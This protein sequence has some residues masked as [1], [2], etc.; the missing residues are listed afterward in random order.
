MF[1]LLPNAQIYIFHRFL[2][3]KFKRNI[4]YQTRKFTHF[5]DF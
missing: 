1:L 4:P 5:T 2:M 3:R